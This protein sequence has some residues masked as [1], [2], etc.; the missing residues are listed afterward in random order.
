MEEE[1]ETKDMND[2]SQMIGD[3]LVNQGLAGEEEDGFGK[4]DPK[5]CSKHR[6]DKV[7]CL[8]KCFMVIVAECLDKYSKVRAIGQ[9]THLRDGMSGS[10]KHLLEYSKGRVGY[11]KEA[12]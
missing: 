6:R 10:S 7:D 12:R 9:E 4:E 5:Q 2:R 11:S 8:D 3:H 1:L